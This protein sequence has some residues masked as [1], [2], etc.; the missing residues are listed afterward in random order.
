MQNTLSYLGQRAVVVLTRGTSDT[1]YCKSI[2]KEWPAAVLTGDILWIGNNL[3]MEICWTSLGSSDCPGSTEQVLHII[4]YFFPRISGFR[5]H[6]KKYKP[7]CHN[8]SWICIDS[9]MYLKLSDITLRFTLLPVRS[10]FLHHSHV[11]HF[12]LVHVS[13][14]TYFLLPVKGVTAIALFYHHTLHKINHYW[15]C[16]WKT[17]SR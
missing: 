1:V 4:P 16:G 17:F 15:K 6:Q 8:E 10:V 11:G 2:W 14:L 3:P 9:R 7:L 13:S 12:Y 5:H